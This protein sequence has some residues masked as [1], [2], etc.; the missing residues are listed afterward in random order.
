[1]T[2]SKLTL[3][4]KHCKVCGRSFY[5]RKKWQQCWSEVRYCSQRCSRNRNK[6]LQSPSAD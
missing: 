4:K 5:W 6:V 3:P 2:H 1:M